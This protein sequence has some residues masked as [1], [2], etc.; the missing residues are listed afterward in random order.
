MEPIVGVLVLLFIVLAAMSGSSSDRDERRNHRDSRRDYDYRSSNQ[1]HRDDDDW[2]DE[3][4]AP[5][6]PPYWPP[7]YY[8]RRRRRRG[9]FMS[10]VLA[11]FAGVFALSVVAVGIYIQYNKDVGPKPDIET[12]KGQETGQVKEAAPVLE[13]KPVKEYEY[14]TK[15]YLICLAKKDYV[16]FRDIQQTYP[17]RKIEAFLDKENRYWIC[18]FVNTSEELD[19]TVGLLRLREA[20][21]NEHGLG[22]VFY[23][24]S[25]LGSGKILREKGTDIWFSQE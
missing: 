19:Q 17:N 9:G 25:Q 18:I 2:D 14:Q 21:L 11:F 7:P 3:Y 22:I 20:D 8:P 15:P 10:L 24:T 1:R 4:G 6:Y 13:I 12:G 16:S 5:F 23:Q